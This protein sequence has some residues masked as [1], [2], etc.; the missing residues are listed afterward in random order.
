MKVTTIMMINVV[1]IRTPR[2]N[3]M[4]LRM[5]TL[6]SGLKANPGSAWILL[7]ESMNCENR[8]VAMLNVSR[9]NRTLA[10]TRLARCY[11]HNVFRTI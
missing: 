7:I 9:P 11:R 4:G 8:A 2:P 3:I 5:G 6:A 1:H 10:M